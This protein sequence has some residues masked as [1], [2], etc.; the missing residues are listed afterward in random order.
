MGKFEFKKVPFG[1]VKAPAYFQWLIDEILSGLDFTFCYFDV[2]LI[3]SPNSK[4][5]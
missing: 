3:Y 2:I 5:H 4:S 1:L